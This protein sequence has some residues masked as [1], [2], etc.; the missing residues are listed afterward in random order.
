MCASMHEHVY[1]PIEISK[2]TKSLAQT[3]VK[4]FKYKYVESESK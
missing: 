1:M 3:K 2:S 4:Y